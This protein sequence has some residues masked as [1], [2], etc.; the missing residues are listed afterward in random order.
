[1][2]YVPCIDSESE[3]GDTQ[4]NYEPRRQEEILDPDSSDVSGSARSVCSGLQTYSISMKAKRRRG[5]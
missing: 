1:M 3:I 4:H 5:R 2:E